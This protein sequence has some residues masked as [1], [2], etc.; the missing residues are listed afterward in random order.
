MEVGGGPRE[1]SAAFHTP[2]NFLILTSRDRVA[3]R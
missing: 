2:L 3:T 1:R